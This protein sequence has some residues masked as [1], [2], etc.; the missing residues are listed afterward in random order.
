MPLLG[1][2]QSLE[3]LVVVKSLGLSNALKHVLN[4]RH[5][6]L[7]TTEVDVGTVAKLI[8][9]LISVFLNLILDVH[10]S[11]VLV[12]LFTGKSVVDTE[13]VWELTLG[14]L[15]LV[16]IKESI[17]VSN[18]KE[19]PGFSLV[20][21]GSR[22]VLEKETADES[23]VWGNSGSG[24]NHDVVGVW[25]LLW[26]K[27]NL[28]GWSS[29]L[30][31]VTWLGVAQEVRA[32]SLLGW[33][34]S[35]ELWAPV[36]G[37]TNTKGSSLSGHIISVTGGGDGVKTNGVWLS[38]LFTSS[39]RD[40]SPGLS[41]PVWEV[42]IVVNDDVASLTSCFWSYNTLGGDNLS[43]ERG[44]VLVYVYRNGGLII[45]WLSLKEVLSGNSG[46]EGWLGAWG[47]SGS[48]CDEGG[49]YSELHVVI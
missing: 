42:A 37:T 11:S 12:L 6:T 10:L 4:S 25:V 45:V 30:N 9:Y 18:S 26:H 24:G 14:L 47:K 22:G 23:T 40:Y 48:R 27:H 46:A 34:I 36:G 32:N 31:L 41:L 39:W 49:K 20:G 35:L 19:E 16:I 5:H 44:L 1:F 15:E 28:S 29:H 38:V 7:K 3:P 8:E 21:A 17:G 33:I 2:L 13:V 43:C